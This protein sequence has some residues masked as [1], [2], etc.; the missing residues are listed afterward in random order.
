MVLDGSVRAVDM[1]AHV[2]AVMQCFS[3]VDWC[4]RA[5]HSWDLSAAFSLRVGGP[6]TSMVSTWLRH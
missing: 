5:R 3:S 6:E 2:H 1:F 4:A